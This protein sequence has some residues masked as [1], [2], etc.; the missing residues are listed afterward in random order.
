MNKGLSTSFGFLLY[1]CVKCLLGNRKR[2]ASGV[3]DC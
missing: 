3:D 2:L 1:I